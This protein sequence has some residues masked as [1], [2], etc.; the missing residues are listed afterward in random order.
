MYELMPHREVESSPPEGI[1]VRVGTGIEDS[2][3]AAVN[4]VQREVAG[5]LSHARIG[6]VVESSFPRTPRTC[7]RTSIRRHTRSTSRCLAGRVCLTRKASRS[8]CAS[9]A[10][11]RRYTI[12][13]FDTS[14]N[15][16]SPMTHIGIVG[17]NEMK[18][19]FPGFTV[20]IER[21][22][23][24]SCVLGVAA[25]AA[26]CGGGE[27]DS[28]DEAGSSTSVQ[29]T[30]SAG[31]RVP[32][33]ANGIILSEKATRVAPR[34]GIIL[35]EK[36]TRVPTRPG[37]ILSEKARGGVVLSEWSAPVGSSRKAD[38]PVADDEEAADE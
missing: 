30:L 33:R 20:L 4:R 38:A 7:H 32:A 11:S 16:H 29:G 9:P 12:A 28:A 13:I 18:K 31:T 1:L 6:D 22:L 26:A 19:R 23:R 17:A 24:L 3:A 8:Q 37:I 10:P 21:A 15:I 14:S 34:P 35:S 36:A 25:L 27:D 2:A 5:S